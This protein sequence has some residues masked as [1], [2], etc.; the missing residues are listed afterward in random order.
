[1]D[2]CNECGQTTDPDWVFCRACGYALDT[3]EMEASTATV[4]ASS[5]TPKVELISRG[6][7]V[8]DVD[9]VETSAD[10]LLDEPT[11]PPL[12]PET[13][14]ISIDNVTVVTQPD[15]NDAAG[16]DGPEESTAGA[17]PEDTDRWDHLRPHGQIS[18]VSETTTM[19][20]RTARFAVL[21]VA[22]GALFAAAARFYLNTR[23]DSFGRGNESAQVVHDVELVA[24][25][26]LLVVAGLAVFAGAAL[27]FWLVMAEGDARFR[28]GPPE[29]ISLAAGLSGV[30]L[31]VIFM[32]ID[33]D[34]VTTAIAANSLVILGLGLVML[35]CLALVR[36][37]TR[38]EFQS[39]R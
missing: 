32:M 20:A 37:V 15:D 13:I 30:A 33:Q 23:L 16:K 38:I 35:G 4:V 8:V 12:A 34:S 18:G 2:F 14:E 9:A 17:Q 19:P 39:P 26:A 6:W 7:D 25:I 1:M 11:E 21:L 28:P 36:S 5:A 27:I 29:F 24:D 31:I 3:P 22:L 10:P